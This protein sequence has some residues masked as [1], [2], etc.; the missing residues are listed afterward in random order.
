MF[1]EA[2]AE[3]WIAKVTKSGEIVFDPFCGRGTAP[4]QA[5][6]MG[7]RAIGNDINP[8]AYC[9]TRAKTRAPSRRAVLSRV[10]RLESEFESMDFTPDAMPP[11]FKYA[12]HRAT[13][14]QLLVLRS[15][16][17]R[18]ESDTDAMVAALALGTLHGDAT[19]SYLSN[20]MPRT[21]STKPGY[22]IRFWKER[23]LRPPRRNAF[24]VIR[25]AAR[26]RYESEPPAA[27][28]EVLLGDMRD[29]PQ[30][31]RGGPLIRTA[32]TSPPY[33]DT[34][35]FEEDQ[36]L[37]LW[38][39]G[40]PPEPSVGRL[41]PD[42]RHSTRDGYWRLIADMWRMLGATLASNSNVVIRLGYRENPTDEVVEMLR[43]TARL[44]RRK[45]RLKTVAESEMRRRQTGSFRPGSVG[46]S[47]EIDAHF[48]L[49]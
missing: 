10:T 37:R 46:Y 20:Q 23:G 45:V 22:S 34:T 4:F 3:T 41:S 11:F 48:T 27:K 5:L 1:P 13:L 19:E 47:R 33:L 8:V 44:A 16:L 28:G 29:L 40:E 43:E 17:K 49:A 38:F 24:D 26:F 2:F 12:Y 36:W 6:L 42:D 35:S 18:R 21:I 32:I 14:A 15:R 39:L 30:K 7:R 25:G 9:V 31:L